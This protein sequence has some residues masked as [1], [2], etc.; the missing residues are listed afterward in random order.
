MGNIFIDYDMGVPQIGC[1]D[2]GKCNSII[3]RS[4]CK[5]TNRGCCHYFPEFT[6]VDIQRMATL[7]GGRKALDM[8]LSNPGTIVNSFN[9]YSKGY[10]DKEAYDQY[11]ASGNI[12]EAGSIR[13]HTIFFRTCPF[14]MP[15]SGCKLPPRFR[16]TVCNFFICAEIL[17]RPDLQDNFKVYLEERSRY[18]RWIYRESGILQH[19]LAEK[20]LNLISDISASMNL[21]AEM[22]PNCYEF[23]S[24]E[25][26]TYISDSSSELC[27][28][29]ITTS[30][31]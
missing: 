15:G 22:N 18:A 28:S 4:L 21:L 27:I 5:I 14:V 31:R 12:M 10:F 8:I 1:T 20:G 11:I 29:P 26:V 7:E 9:I 30:T 16:T 2:C 23:P 6:L 3:G 17:E 24:L 13:D 25:P 19:I